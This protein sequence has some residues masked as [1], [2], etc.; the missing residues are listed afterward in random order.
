MFSPGGSPAVPDEPVVS[1]VQVSAVAHQL[2]G[3]VQ[4]NV[5]LVVAPTEDSTAV[6]LPPAGIRGDSQRALSDWFN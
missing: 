4:S 3:V 6:E 1:V 2:D 5:V